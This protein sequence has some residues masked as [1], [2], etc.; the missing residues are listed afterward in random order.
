MTVE[1]FPFLLRRDT[2]NTPYKSLII[3][4]FQPLESAAQRAGTIISLA[5]AKYGYHEYNRKNYYRLTD[6]NSVRSRS[7]IADGTG[8]R[9]ED[10]EEY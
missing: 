6:W 8:Y 2:Q 7:R 5:Y 3:I 10:P 9:K 1:E 4:C